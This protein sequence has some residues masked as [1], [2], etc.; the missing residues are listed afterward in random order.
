[1]KPLVGLT[2]GIASGKSTVAQMF[3]ALGVPVIDA[4][5]LAR[6]VV[7]PGSAGLKS[8]VDAFGARILRDDGSLNRELMAELA[9]K[10]ES[11]RKQLNHITHP[12][13]AQA[14]QALLTQYQKSDAPFIIYEA[15]LLV[16][17]KAHLAFS[18]LIVVDAH[19]EH[20]ITR[21]FQRNQMSEEQTRA[22]I[23]AQVS[24]EMRRGAATYVIENFGDLESLKKQ[25]RQ[26][27]D[28][29]L[30]LFPS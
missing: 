19:E 13:I 30:K 23:A 18:A 8:L 4:D 17:N 2:G 20:Q 16:E 6:E 29:L 21:S 14:S 7:Q 12:L 28:Q 25:V 27:Y 9:F 5:E 22:R 1:M 10:D 15:A 24:R 26:V 11:V 3:N